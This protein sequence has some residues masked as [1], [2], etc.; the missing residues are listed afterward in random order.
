M[1][2][3]LASQYSEKDQIAFCAEELTRMGITVVSTWH[4]EEHAPN[5]SLKEFSADTLIPLAE[6]DL[7]EIEA[8]DLLLLFTVDP[9][10][11]TRRGG[12]RTADRRRHRRTIRDGFGIMGF[13]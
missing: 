11:M 4:L 12:R 8:C 13:R 5:S 2:I 10:A 3:Y 1:K 6:R 9:D 7:K